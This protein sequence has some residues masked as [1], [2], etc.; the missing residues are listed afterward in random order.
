LLGVGTPK[1]IIEMVKRG[2]DMFDCVY[3]TRN[4]RHGSIFVWTDMD[5]LEYEAIK[6]SSSRFAMDF[7]PIATTSKLSELQNYT[8]A[9]LHHLFRAKELLAYR[10]ATLN[11]L[12][13]Y[14]QLM[15]VLRGK[16]E[17][18]EV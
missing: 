1:D 12:E 18:G 6:I 9:Y 2:I 8:K 10:L 14:L 5:K 16:I 13:F 11:N 4:A 3:P 17:C 7:S 15:E